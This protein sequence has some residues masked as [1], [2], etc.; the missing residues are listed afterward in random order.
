M[1]CAI[2]IIITITA[3]SMQAGAFA[4]AVPAHTAPASTIEITPESTYQLQGDQRDHESSTVSE[5]L[6]CTP[7][8]HNAA[9]ATTTTTVCSPQAGASANETTSSTTATSLTPEM[10]DTPNGVADALHGSTSPAKIFI[11]QYSVPRSLCDDPH[12]DQRGL[13]P[14]TIEFTDNAA[15]RRIA[16]AAT[17]PSREAPPTPNMYHPS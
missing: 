15:A 9:V 1:I 8:P 11:A 16:C 2:K 3:C 10:L 12:L 14:T 7:V 5:A 4:I 6:P 13:K 17:P